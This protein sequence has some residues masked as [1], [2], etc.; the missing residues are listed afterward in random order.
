MNGTVVFFPIPF[1]LNNNL[2]TV[3]NSPIDYYFICDW[4]DLSM[5][6]KW[7][8]TP[9]SNSTNEP[10]R[11]HAHKQWNIFMVCKKKEEKGQ[12]IDRNLGKSIE[13]ASNVCDMQ[14]QHRRQ[15]LEEK[16]SPFDVSIIFEPV[17]IH[18]T[19]WHTMQSIIADLCEPFECSNVCV[20]VCWCICLNLLPWHTGIC[21][22]NHCAYTTWA[23]NRIDFAKWGWTARSH[24]VK[25]G[26][27]V[28]S[29]Q[30]VWWRA[31]TINWP[32][33]TYTHTWCHIKIN[34]RRFERKCPYDC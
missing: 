5:L 12:N 18:L 4:N 13:I 2:T 10:T 33:F 19:N 23:H 15:R 27:D 7:F 30:L 32:N 26:F 16:E 22:W 34:C 31:E 9:C 14:Q 11:T 24:T 21:D 29:Q 1:C 3:E 25:M 6:L 17:K 20:C 8:D 28:K